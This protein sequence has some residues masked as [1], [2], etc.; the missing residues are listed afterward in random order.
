VLVIG[1]AKD[2]AV[3]AAH[4]GAA[5]VLYDGGSH[6]RHELEETG[7]PVASSLTEAVA[8]AGWA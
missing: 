4:V 1:D 7:F 2:D 6:P 3:A 8:L 5:C